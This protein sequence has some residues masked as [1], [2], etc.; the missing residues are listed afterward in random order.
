MAKVLVI[1][2][3]AR[4]H[5]LGRQLKLSSQVERVYC[6]PGNPGMKSD[7]IEPVAIDVMD[8]NG[9]I[10]FAQANQIDLTVVGP[11][12]PLQAG[13]VDNFLAAGLTI[14]GPTKSAARLEGSKTFAKQMMAAAEVPTA[15]YVSY[16]DETKACEALNQVSYPVVIKADGL[17]GGKGVVIAENQVEA[18][19]VIHQMLG[20]HQFNTQSVMLEEFLSGQELSLMAFINDDQII[21]MPL[22]QDHKAAYDGDRGPNTGGMGAYSPLPQFSAGFV[23]EAVEQIMRPLIQTLKQQGITFCGVL[24]A[25]LMLTATG[26]KVIEFNVRLGDP[27]TVVVLPQLQ[28]DLYELIQ[29]LLKHKSVNARWKTED[30]YLGVVVS[31]ESYPQSASMGVDLCAFKQS[32]ADLKVNY[33]GVKEDSGQLLTNGGRILCITSQAQSLQ[34]AQTKLYKWLDRQEIAGLRYRHDIGHRAIN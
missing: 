6:A 16:D 21:P 3:G 32:P 23:D 5:A 25:G 22:S 1:G 19:K 15:H 34:D 20:E 12:Q 24:Y 31:A 8:F 7:Q 30:F 4:E 33:A 10:H 9:L 11:E 29:S 2:S 17:A 27:E 28:S 26:L 14:F 13:I 18:Q